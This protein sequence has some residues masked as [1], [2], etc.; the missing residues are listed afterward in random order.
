MPAGII[1]YLRAMITAAGA[2]PS[3]GPGLP[4]P[5]VGLPLLPISRDRRPCHAGI[6]GRSIAGGLHH[7]DRLE[8]WAARG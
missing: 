8:T 1:A 7:E 4:E 3:L 5:S 6:V 2:T